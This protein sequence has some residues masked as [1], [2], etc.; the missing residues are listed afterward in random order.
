MVTSGLLFPIYGH[1]WPTFPDIWSQVAYFSRYHYTPLCCLG[2]SLQAFE[3]APVSAPKIAQI[4]WIQQYSLFFSLLAGNSQWRR[5]RQ[6]LRPPP[7]SPS[8]RKIS[9]RRPRSPQLAVF[10]GCV[11]VSADTVSGLKAIL[12][13]LSLGRGIPFPRCRSIWPAQSDHG[14]GACLTYQGVDRAK[15]GCSAT[16]AVFAR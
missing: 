12:G 13:R 16:P 15:S 6:R 14:A 5:F 11:S 1:K 7:R 4:R 9:R 3:F 8:N 10:G 2:I